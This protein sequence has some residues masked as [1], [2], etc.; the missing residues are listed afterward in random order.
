MKKR[1]RADRAEEVRDALSLLAVIDETRSLFHRLKRAAEELHRD[2]GLTAGQ[3]AVL[4]S[5]QNGGPQT[6]PELARARPVSRQHIQ[7]L[8]NPMVRAGWV[9]LEENPRHARSKL[10]ALSPLGEELLAAVD[11][12]EAVVFATLVGRFDVESLKKTAETLREV[13]SV[14]SGER[15]QSLVESTRGRCAGSKG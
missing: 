3:R 1:E 5:L 13:G 15:W 14:F 4:K 9:K 7:S 8:V 12:R 2:D 6:V 11:A 10:V